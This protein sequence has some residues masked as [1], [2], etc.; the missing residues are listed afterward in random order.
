LIIVKSPREIDSM[1]KAGKIVAIVLQRLKEEV[2][3][4]MKTRDLDS[5]AVDELQKHRAKASFKDY[6]GYPA[7]L[8]VSINDEIVHGI[9]GDRVIDEGDI[10]SLDFGACIDGFHGD[11]AIT[12][13]VGNISDEARDLL[14]VTE[15]SLMAGINKAHNG[16][17]LG[18]VSVTI[19]EYVE[20]RGFSVVRE[21]CGH[22]IG[23]DLHEDPQIPNFGIRGKGPVL[24]EGMTLA[25]EP[26]VNV[27][28]WKTRVEADKWT[29]R[30]A[31]NSLSAHFEHTIAI[32]KNEPEILTVV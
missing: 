23:R 9:P 26:M 19:Q 20:T 7:H 25:L 15:A 16:V 21:Y 18:D 24:Q 28:S 29:V 27:G 4:G 12:I 3:P 32:G 8:C 6:R 22:G 2:R 14:E 5:I 1:R 17:K 11:A 10:V 31:D 13:G 30:T